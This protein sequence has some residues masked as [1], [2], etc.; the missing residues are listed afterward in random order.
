MSVREIMIKGHFLVTLVVSTGQTHTFGNLRPAIPWSPMYRLLIPYIKPSVRESMIKSHWA[1]ILFTCGL[2]SSAGL[3]L[4]RL[5]NA[6]RIAILKITI[7]LEV[8]RFCFSC[9]PVGL[10]SAK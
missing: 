6:R 9:I 8:L 4:Y 1:P 5:Q 2:P 7:I 3:P 10:G